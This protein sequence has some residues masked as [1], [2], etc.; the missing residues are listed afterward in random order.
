MGELEEHVRPGHF[1]GHCVVNKSLSIQS[2]PFQRS[3]WRASE[4]KKPNRPFTSPF[5][6]LKQ[7]RRRITGTAKPQPTGPPTPP[8]PVRTPSFLP[9]RFSPF[10]TT[11]PPR[12]RATWL[13]HACYLLEFPSGIR[14]LFDPVFS[15]R[16]S[17]F[18]W[19][20][21]KRYTPAP[22]RLADIPILDAVVISHDHYDHLDHASVM[23]VV[24]RH[25]GVRFFVPLG[26][27]KRL[28][29]WGVEG[30]SVVEMDW[31]EERELRLTLRVAEAGDD[32]GAAAAEAAGREDG[33]EQV[34]ESGQ[35]SRSAPDAS[36]PPLPRTITARIGCLP[37][38]HTSA[39]TPFDKARSLWASWSVSSDGISVYFAGDT[40]YRTVPDFPSPCPSS[41]SPS[42]SP[43]SPHP[44]SHPPHPS[45]D[46]P[47]PTH[48]NPKHPDPNHDYSNPQHP[49]CPAFRQIGD[50]RG[51]FDLGLIPI[52]AY[53][54]RSLFSAM[55]A[56]PWDS[57]R[58]FG[59][60]RCR[61]AL[62]MHW[63]TWVLTEEDAWAP[64]RGLGEAVREAGL[65]G[66]QDGEGEEVFGVCDVGESREF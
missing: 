40:G 57:V 23:Q 39:R 31:W 16:C 38:Q 41:P 59:D 35:P 55:H 51:P 45:S 44:P 14:V 8:I 66:K 53:E 27:R 42:L 37:C 24:E 28:E 30:G 17:P 54:P 3:Q 32:G 34:E 5:S 18:S 49:H 56:D 52:G 26:N 11:T 13:G 48:P 36:S 25:P 22:C 6:P 1:P 20:G 9:T 2:P 29:G 7:T 33:V 46:Q 63:G 65:G 21:P 12:L 15:D 10:T 43:P 64:V 62:G 60:T 58:I 19:L 61:R 4:K 50:L 47:N